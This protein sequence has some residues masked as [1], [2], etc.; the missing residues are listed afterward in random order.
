MK[1]KNLALAQDKIDR[2]KLLTGASTDQ[3]AMEI[4]LD[5]ALGEAEADE[6]IR[7]ALR[8]RWAAADRGELYT[9]EVFPSRQLPPDARQR[10]EDA[11]VELADLPPPR[12]HSAR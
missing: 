9:E 12:R 4:A 2:L 8:E 3:A 10:L 6:E 7:A 5:R 11:G 1:W